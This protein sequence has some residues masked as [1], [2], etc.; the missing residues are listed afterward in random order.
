MVRVD[1]GCIIC[2]TQL[3]TW[4]WLQIPMCHWVWAKKA[5]NK[6]ASCKVTITDTPINP[7]HNLFLLAVFKII[8][9]CVTFKNVFVIEISLYSGPQVGIC[10]GLSLFISGPPLFPGH[11]YLIEKLSSPVWSLLKPAW[12]IVWFGLCWLCCLVCSVYE[13]ITGCSVEFVSVCFFLHSAKTCK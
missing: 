12:P 3:L 4:A 13:I 5:F 6:H 2:R 8:F 1:G 9:V 10:V 11:S 7:D